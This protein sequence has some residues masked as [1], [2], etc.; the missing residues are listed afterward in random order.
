MIGILE[1]IIVGINKDSKT[2][3][4]RYINARKQQQQVQI[5]ILKQL[6]YA[7]I[8]KHNEQPIAF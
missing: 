6:W 3:N 1:T 5:Q 2:N 4:N 7:N 8:T